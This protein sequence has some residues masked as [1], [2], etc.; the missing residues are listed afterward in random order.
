MNFTD[1]QK[2]AIN[3]RD[4]SLI[5]SAGAGSGKT[6]VLTERI[7]ERI[8]D[9][10]DDCNI[11][12]FLI[13][14][15]T[16]AA[17]KELSDRIRNKLSERAAN[18]PRNKKILN[19][20]ALLPLAKIKTI[21]SFCYEIVRDNFQKLGLSASV[22]IAD[23]AETDVIREKLMNEVVDDYFET[24]GDDKA[25]IAAYEIFASAKNDK[26]FVATLLDLDKKLSNLTDRN[27]FCKGVLDAYM[28]TSVGQE[29][30]DTYYG[31]IM[32]DS[33][34]NDA[35]K[36]MS[37]LEGLMLECGKYDILTEKYY[38]VIEHEYEFAR[39]VYHECDKGYE[40]VCN[41][42]NDHKIM[43]F[44]GKIVPKTFENN[45]LKELISST[46]KAAGDG[47]VNNLKSLCSCDS[48][49][50]RS[51]AKDTHTVLAKLFELV[52]IFRKKLDERK[53]EL[54]II[55][56]SDAEAYT[57]SL[58][59]EKENPFTVTDFA[60]QL[61]SSFEEIYIDEYQ[62]VNPLQ[63]MIFRAISRHSDGREYNRFMVGDIKQSIYRFRGAS[64]D[65]FMSY[66]DTFGDI[67]SDDKTKRIFMS[68]NFRCCESVI[69]LTNTVFER[70]MGSYYTDGD[71]LEF[72]RPEEKKNTQKVCISAFYYDKEEADGVS[73]TELEAA[74]ICEKIKEFVHN[75]AYTKTD[76]SE[77]TYSDI[78]ILSRSKASLKVYESV[79]NGA[80]IPVLSGVGESFYGKKE[81]IL[82]LDILNAIDNPERDIYLAGFMRSFAGNFSDDELALIRK[83]Y[84]NMSLYRALVKC[85]ENI[86]EDGV[87]GEKCHSFVEKLRD[88]R[89]FSR[90]KSA[91]KLLWKLYNDM[92][93]INMCSSDGFTNDKTST[94]KNLLKLYQMARDFS[95]T[96]F[97]GVGAFVDYINGS[98][99]KSDVKSERES[100]GNCVA[101][102]TVHAS[103]GLE[104]PI[105]FV[106]NLSKKFNKS[107]EKERL[108]FSEKT[109]IATNLCDTEAIESVESN[110]AL[111]NINTP[112]RTV[113]SN[114]I[115][116]E[117][118]EEEVR[119]L[120]VAM[121]RARD[122]LVLTSA[123]PKKTE[124]AMKEVVTI[125]FSKN[126][127]DTNNYFTMLLASIADMKSLSPFYLAAGMTPYG[128]NDAC[129]DC[130]ECEYIECGKVKEMYDAC[131]NKDDFEEETGN[132]EY[133][134]KLLES[135]KSLSA[136]VHE[137]DESPAKVTVSQLKIGLI[138]PENDVETVN[139]D[140]GDKADPVPY[141]V[142][143]EKEFD[144]AQKGTA[145]HMFMQFANYENC[146]C[147]CGKEADRLLEQG[148]IDELQRKH[149]DIEKLTRFFASDF[150]LEIAKSKSIYREQRFNLDVDAFDSPLR[151]NI[152]VQGVID[153]FYQND[154]GTY[155][156]VDFKTDRVFGDGAEQVLI[157]RHKQQLMYYKRAVEE[158]TGMPV[159]KTVIYSFSLMKEI[160]IE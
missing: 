143:G 40:A 114:T 68:N 12:D 53:K 13:V 105:C 76:G 92:D 148:F 54:S 151:G 160:D 18:E 6:A 98:M 47:F 96:S 99:E 103:K 125:H 131:Q 4:C 147:D 152:L 55:E 138:D 20:L 71:R 35:E 82:C 123:F 66:R 153:L 38:P 137:F 67:G 16:N 60:N 32:K 29:F 113:I 91:D 9:E 74:L 80:G 81:I 58:L 45:M 65:I 117:L 135:L 133:D 48:K 159:S 130:L 144:A 36:T 155:T 26:G 158:M 139:V 132:D 124:N 7:L 120:Y 72:S 126:Y 149:L 62:D 63:D 108:V 116:N 39:L 2:N 104:F 88:Y 28:Q 136:K 21:N 140:V 5:V 11:D 14:T 77:Y 141:F 95:G 50:L 73:S 156:V 49:L 102:M 150:Y 34:K 44:A 1:N 157:E 128:D 83:K 24:N 19:N 30:F 43:T 52:E 89:V 69:K 115:D 100:T 87:L 111:I 127:T 79:L 145:M 146:A 10:N 101:L 42:V 119:I 142:S 110:T 154:D 41:L 31:K 134:E 75:P 85:S 121:T 107:D 27:A 57:L 56:F 118:T 93:I 112:F 22:R 122:K 3:V 64:S 78:G 23:E 70:L 46:K 109:G 17:A 33:I 129:D 25:F 97:R 59:V 51:C 61:R 84:R 106:S 8:C 37:V 94:R 15:F 90:G 86:A